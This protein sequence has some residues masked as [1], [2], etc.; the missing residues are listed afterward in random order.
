MAVR[1]SRAAST[2]VPA[3]TRG[4]RDPRIDAYVANAAEFARPILERV[5]ET[6]HAAC[7]DV[8]ETLKWGFPH[9]VHGGRILCGVAAFR[10]H[11]AL[12][13]WLGE[14]VTG[15]PGSDEAMGQFG[16]LAAL[17]DL[18]PKRTLAGWVR[19]AMALGRAGAKPPGRA[20]RSPRPPAEV[21]ADLAAA[22][23]SNRKA[24]AT[25]DAFSNSH[26]REYIEWIGEAKRETTR[27]QRLAT[28]I[29]WLAEG[30]PRNWKYDRRTA[31]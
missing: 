11:V 21:P 29:E 17:A 15:T 31:G 20:R 26:R 27:A 18:P 12:G 1:A 30:K 6:V 14:R 28:T 10:R 19:K 25:F 23:A 3:R 16:R 9:F 8:E 4:A 2:R 5:R 22:L 13:F 7:P 24:R